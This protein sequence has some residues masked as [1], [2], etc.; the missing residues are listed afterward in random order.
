[1][2]L[3]LFG[4]EGISLKSTLFSF[5]KFNSICIYVVL[6]H[7][8]KRILLLYKINQKN[9]SF[10]NYLKNYIC[11]LQRKQ[12]ETKVN[13]H[14]FRTALL[15]HVKLW[16][17]GIGFVLSSAVGCLS[18]CGSL[19]SSANSTCCTFSHACNISNSK[20]RRDCLLSCAV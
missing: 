13:R 15:H 10:V 2:A 3:D 17:T 18:Q 19:K 8:A 6:K 9:D 7:H 20:R 1:M 4:F 14:F 12:S 11:Q 5:P 16:F